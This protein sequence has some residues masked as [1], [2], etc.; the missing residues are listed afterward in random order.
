MKNEI[1]N[2]KIKAAVACHA[3]PS[4]LLVSSPTMQ[5][6]TYHSL[7]APPSASFIRCSN[8]GFKG[9]NRFQLFQQTQLF[10]PNWLACLVTS[11]F[12][13]NRLLQLL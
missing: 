4:T 5:A 2:K 1:K 8:L 7:N 11:L 12:V 3:S 6:K 9:R 10:C 13:L